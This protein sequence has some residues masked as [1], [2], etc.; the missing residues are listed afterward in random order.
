M[1]QFGLFL[2]I[3][4]HQLLTFDSV[5][6]PHLKKAISK[7]TLL[8]TIQVSASTRCLFL[9]FGSFGP[10]CV[11]VGSA[12]TMRLGISSGR[13]DL[14]RCVSAPRERDKK[15]F[16]QQG[17]ACLLARGGWQAG[18]RTKTKYRCIRKCVCWCS[19]ICGGERRCEA[20]RW[21][22]T[23]CVSGVTVLFDF[24]PA[25]RSRR[26]LGR[27]G[28]IRWKGGSILENSAERVRQAALMEIPLRRPG[29][30]GHGG[31]R[32]KHHAKRRPWKWPRKSN[33]PAGRFQL[34][35]HDTQG[36]LLQHKSN[37]RCD[38]ENEREWERRQMSESVVIGELRWL[39]P[40]A[41]NYTFSTRSWARVCVV[42]LCLR[43]A[44]K[45]PAR[46]VLPRG[47]CSLFYCPVGD[48]RSAISCL[49][50]ASRITNNRPLHNST[51]VCHW[52]AAAIFWQS[53]GDVTKNS[54]SASSA[55]D[56]DTHPGRNLQFAARS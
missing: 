23:W 48:A 11:F 7:P 26:I 36:A 1:H 17:A 22:R 30:V 49:V 9:R 51:S 13:A 37:L 31:F 53:G 2:L 54:P 21:L 43:R 12:R 35:A 16:Q 47:N 39:R 6:F 50:C 18:I 41:R 44:E 14:S 45:Q 52:T 55:L 10:L 15:S 34:A 28:Q 25:W 42:C 3:L 38:G 33:D 32:L 40:S 27:R 8:R 56:P 5:N 20:S 19:G 46:L 4:E 29:P 24:P